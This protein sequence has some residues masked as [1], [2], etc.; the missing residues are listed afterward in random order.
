MFMAF[1]QKKNLLYEEIFSYIMDYWED[2][3]RLVQ[4]PLGEG[5]RQDEI[6]ER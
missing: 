5:L 4:N 6:V 2:I 3:I 1:L